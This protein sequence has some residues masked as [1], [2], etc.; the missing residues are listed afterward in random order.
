MVTKLDNPI[1]AH[2]LAQLRNKNTQ[3]KIFR[4]LIQEISM[5]MIYEVGREFE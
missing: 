3:P 4:E 2:K 1:I 5:L